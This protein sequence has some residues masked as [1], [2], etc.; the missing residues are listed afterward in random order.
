MTADDTA[1]EPTAREWEL[2][3]PYSQLGV[4]ASV[5]DLLA[6]YREELRAWCREQ[7]DVAGAGGSYTLGWRDGLKYAADLLAST[8][9][10]THD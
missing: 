5:A 1:P 6:S 9:E 3:D 2:A 10:D 8:E 7:A 4:R